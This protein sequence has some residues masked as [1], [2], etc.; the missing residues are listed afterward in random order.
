MEVVILIL[1]LRYVPSQSCSCAFSVLIF[2]HYFFENVLYNVCLWPLT[3]SCVVYVVKEV[4][5]FRGARSIMGVARKRTLAQALQTSRKK[6][7]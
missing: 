1:L 3:R 2:L 5:S 4:T 6:A 7:V